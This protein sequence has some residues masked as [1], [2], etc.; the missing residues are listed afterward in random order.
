MHVIVT[1]SELCMVRNTEVTPTVHGYHGNFI[2]ISSYILTIKYTIMLKFVTNF[3]CYLKHS[4]GAVFLTGII[5]LFSVS[6]S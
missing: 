3:V 2:F 5:T 1:E 6:H 4:R